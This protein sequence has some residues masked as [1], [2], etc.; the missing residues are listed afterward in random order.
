MP[1]SL[2]LYISGNTKMKDASEGNQTGG[3]AGGKEVHCQTLS[4]CEFLFSSF[5][6]Q[7]SLLSEKS[8]PL[9]ATK[10]MLRRA[11]IVCVNIV[12]V[13]MCACHDITLSLSLWHNKT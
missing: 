7:W 8:V 3:K 6:N 2:S 12:P 4:L 9:S 5:T 1:L 10:L 13:V 11:S